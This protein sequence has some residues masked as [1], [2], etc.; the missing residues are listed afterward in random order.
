[1]I[2]KYKEYEK[3]ILSL[4]DE[5]NSKQSFLYIESENILILGFGSEISN[6]RAT[7]GNVIV[8][9]IEPKEINLNNVKFINNDLNSG[10]PDL[11]TKF[12][13]VVA[14]F[15]MEYI[16]EK[17]IFFKNIIEKLTNSGI[18]VIGLWFHNRILSPKLEYKFRDF[19]NKIGFKIINMEVIERN[20]ND[21]NFMPKVLFITLERE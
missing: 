17:K 4:V 12:D 18:V 19:F 14:N 5:L 7:A 10:F 6:L 20:V 9:D 11:S 8:I 16:Q 15:I 21:P 3:E 13:L 2:K 1:M